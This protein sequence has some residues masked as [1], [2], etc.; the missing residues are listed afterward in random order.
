MELAEV[1]AGDRIGLLN[2]AMHRDVMGGYRW[3]P[4]EVRAEPYGLDTATAAEGA[5]P[6]LL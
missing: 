5:A 4:E 1:G 2:R 3:P 6:R